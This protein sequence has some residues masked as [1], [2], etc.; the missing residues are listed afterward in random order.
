VALM[1]PADTPLIRLRSVLCVADEL[2]VE[3]VLV[4]KVLFRTWRLIS[5]ADFFF[6]SF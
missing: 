3:L 1:P 6:C 4:V 2:F 5:Y